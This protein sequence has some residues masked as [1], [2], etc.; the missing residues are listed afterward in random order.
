MKF[1]VSKIYL[2]TIS[3]TQ[4]KDILGKS[5]FCKKFEI[6]I[7]QNVSKNDDVVLPQEIM[8][9]L[10]M[11]NIYNGIIKDKKTDTKKS[12][13][14]VINS[15]HLFERSTNK[16]LVDVFLRHEKNFH[17]KLF[18]LLKDFSRQ[19]ME[20][21]SKPSNNFSIFHTTQNEQISVN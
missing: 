16:L 9:P 19:A 21:A 5:L 11:K 14:K 2:K 20:L 8:K 1:K 3:A 13:Q 4:E 12:L 10:K 15:S 18:C 6:F 17:R 7:K